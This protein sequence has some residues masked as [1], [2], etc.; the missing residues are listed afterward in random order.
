M[1]SPGAQAE[2][3]MTMIAQ[4]VRGFGRVIVR[5]SILVAG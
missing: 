3:A 2:V 1:R 4:A 5:R